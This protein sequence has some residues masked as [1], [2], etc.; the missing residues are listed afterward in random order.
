MKT[1]LL[2]LA[3]LA[4]V[5]LAPGLA[6]AVTTQLA[7]AAIW[8]SAQP[9]LVGAALGALTWRHATRAKT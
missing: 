7:A 4:L 5:L 9:V 6:V 8:V 1:T 2:L 3:L